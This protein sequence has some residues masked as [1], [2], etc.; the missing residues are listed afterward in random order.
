MVGGHEWVKLEKIGIIFKNA[1]LGTVSDGRR[2]GKFEDSDFELLR[3]CITSGCKFSASESRNSA[4]LS[5]D[6]QV[7]T[8]LRIQKFAF[9]DKPAAVVPVVGA[10][11]VRVVAQVY[12]TTKKLAAGI[13]VVVLAL[14]LRG[15]QGL[16]IIDLS[17]SAR[18]TI[19]FIIHVILPIVVAGVATVEDG[20]MG[21][22]PSFT[23]VISLPPR[24]P[25][26]SRE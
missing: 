3:I 20:L 4:L 5:A 25:F 16:A 24:G 18:N 19:E 26:W 22:Y 7:R 21:G 9:A 15:K 17:Q 13:A 6:R 10:P 11:G 8:S 2:Y 23:G 12:S 14:I 1:R